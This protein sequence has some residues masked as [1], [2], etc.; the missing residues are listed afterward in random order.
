M[1]KIFNFKAID[2]KSGSTFLFSMVKGGNDRKTEVAN[3]SKF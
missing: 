3:H 2:S 1:A